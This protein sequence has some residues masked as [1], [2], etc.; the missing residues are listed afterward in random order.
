MYPNVR[1]ARKFSKYYP[2]IELPADKNNWHIGHHCLNVLENLYPR[3]DLLI[4]TLLDSYEID[5]AQEEI[6]NIKRDYLAL[7]L[8][9][10]FKDISKLYMLQAYAS[11][12]KHNFVRNLERLSGKMKRLR[13]AI[14]KADD[15]LKEARNRTDFFD[16]IEN[17]HVCNCGE[18][19]HMT[20]VV[21]R[22]NE[23]PF[24][25]VCLRLKNKEGRLLHDN[26]CFCL[27]RMDNKDLTFK[28]MMADLYHPST[29]IVDWWL[30]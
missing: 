29:L 27:V 22:A 6:C 30:G 10:E 7:E 12:F 4:T 2:P 18:M 21:L 25:S 20:S 28:Q 16:M 11:F 17:E 5:K 23:N 1:L 26:H 14:D 19:G 13:K 3:R 8:S 15:I 24:Q 9:K